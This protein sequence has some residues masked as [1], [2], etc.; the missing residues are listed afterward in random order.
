[1]NHFINK[2]GGYKYLFKT[3]ELY[4]EF[5]LNVKLDF[6][7]TGPILTEQLVLQGSRM[8]GNIFTMSFDDILQECND[9]F[10]DILCVV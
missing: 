1:M 10:D 4:K 2:V 5:Y 6:G 9:K 8:A 3:K 7:E